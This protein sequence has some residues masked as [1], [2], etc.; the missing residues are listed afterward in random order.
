MCRVINSN[1]AGWG[2][3]SRSRV[4]VFPQTEAAVHVDAGSKCDRGN[5]RPYNTAAAV[6][7]TQNGRPLVVT[8]QHGGGPAGAAGTCRCW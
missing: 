4:W 1:F 3:A 6:L 7:V 2:R 8:G 5:K